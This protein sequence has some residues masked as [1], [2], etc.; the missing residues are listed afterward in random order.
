MAISWG[1]MEKKWSSLVN[2]W[3]RNGGHGGVF[4]SSW[5]KKSEGFHEKIPY[6]RYTNRPAISVILSIYSNHACFGN[7]YKPFPSFKLPLLHQEMALACPSLPESWNTQRGLH[8]SVARDQEKHQGSF[9]HEHHEPLISINWES[10]SLEKI[11]D[12]YLL[13]QGNCDGNWMWCSSQVRE[14][15]EFHSFED[16]ESLHFGSLRSPGT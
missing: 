15:S 12:L 3:I 5:L 11:R 4:T 13:E 16:E 2:H 9:N 10:K 1:P 8:E 7:I 14:F 6:I